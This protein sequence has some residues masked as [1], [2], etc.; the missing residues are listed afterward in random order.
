MFRMTGSSSQTGSSTLVHAGDY[1]QSYSNDG[2][3][4]IKF[5]NWWDNLAPRLG[6]TWD[7]TGKAKVSSCELCHFHRSSDAVGR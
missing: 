4:Y 6:L 7:F 3:S 1:Q 2:T 5:N